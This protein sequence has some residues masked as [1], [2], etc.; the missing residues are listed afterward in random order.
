MGTTWQIVGVIDHPSVDMRKPRSLSAY[1][2]CQYFILFLARQR[3]I[4][5]TVCM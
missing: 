1:E 4:R 3:M 2:N 5:L